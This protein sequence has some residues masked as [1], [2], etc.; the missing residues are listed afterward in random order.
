MRQIRKRKKVKRIEDE[1]KN[2]SIER[3][4]IEILNEDNRQWMIKRRKLNEK[5]QEIEENEEKQLEKKKRLAIAE[6]KKK[7][8][9][10]DMRKKGKIKLTQ[11]ERERLEQ[12][13]KYW[14]NFREK[15]EEYVVDE[16]NMEAGDDENSIAGCEITTT[17]SIRPPTLRI[18]KNPTKI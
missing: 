16:N 15:E 9:I 2:P 13:K 7:E 14:R 11:K 10:K 3:V 5:I 6:K 4:C 17:A 1:M 8:L 12:R 18:P